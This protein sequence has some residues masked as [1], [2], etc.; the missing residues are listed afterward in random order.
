MAITSYS[1]FINE[2][3]SLL[4][5]AAIVE[6]DMQDAGFTIIKENKLLNPAVISQL[7][8]VPKA[9]RTI[10]IGQL[11]KTD[12]TFKSAMSELFVYYIER[13]IEEN[14]LDETNV[15]RV[16]K[17]SVMTVNKACTV[18]LIEGIYFSKKNTFNFFMNINKI[19]IFGNVLDN[20]V[21]IKN[22]G[23][24]ALLEHDKYIE[25]FKT[26]FK[27][28]NKG[29]KDELFGLLDKI[30][31]QYL[32][33]TLPLDYYREF[34]SSAMYKVA[35][36]PNTYLAEVD[37]SFREKLYIEYNYVNVIMPLFKLLF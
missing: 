33:R 3:M 2:N 27:Y 37:E 5:N 1:N 13:F 24:D 25:L 34:N 29:M 31:S 12:N 4:T 32:E 35:S 19:L 17:D 11:Q 6:Y 20:T 26:V 30:R 36:D 16:T 18:Q 23:D 14:Q 15:L 9:I 22:L 8:Q 21:K 7:E 28:L 10:Q